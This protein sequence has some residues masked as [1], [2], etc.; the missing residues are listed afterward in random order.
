VTDA[1]VILTGGA[2]A[3]TAVAGAAVANR[4]RVPGL[5]LF[6]AL[7]MAVGS[8]GAGWLAF[9]DYDAAQR[10]GTIALAL[11]L[12]EGGLATGVETIRHVL[13][14]AIHL[15]VVGTIVTAL[16]TGIIASALLQV[17]L[18]QGMLLGAVLSSTDGAAIFALLRGS[19]LRRRLARTLEAESGL[20]DPIAVILVVGLIA[21]I[22]N[23]GYGLIDMAGLFVR[24]LS[25]GAACGGLVAWASTAAVKRVWLPTQGLYPVA[26]FGAAALAYGAAASLG[27][28]SFLAVYLVGLAFASPGIPARQT[29]AAFHA[30]AAWIGQIALFVSLGLLVAP[31]QLA[32]V[33]AE[34]TLLALAIMLVARPL[35]TLVA[36][37]RDRFSA[38]EQLVLSWAGLRGGVPV[39]FATFPVTAGVPGSTRFFDIVFFAVVLS[40]F[41]QGATFER[42]AAR[43]GLTTRTPALPR[44]LTDVGVIRG[45]G[46]EVAE[47]GLAEGD[48]VIGRHVRDLG[49]PSSAI[50][51]IIVRGEE[52]VLPRGSTRLEAGDVLH[53]LIRDEVA[54]KMPL[55]VERWRHGD[56]AADQ[57]PPGPAR[58]DPARPERLVVQPWHPG[59]GDAAHPAAVRGAPVVGRLLG[60]SDVRGALVRLDDGRLAATGPVLAVGRPHEVGRYAVER[61]RMAQ[62]PAERSWWE[63]VAAA[64]DGGSPVRPTPPPGPARSARTP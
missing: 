21:W 16:V 1:A 15:A 12:F 11:I 45:L 5:L 31:S 14:P 27:G 39:V 30:G 7:G 47:V 40:T 61:R 64:A 34:G 13:R 32:G 17:S 4:L 9:T 59:L 18:L 2:L 50:V 55:L 23:P 37:A 49:L 52:A 56:P 41:L 60:R 6:L 46:A 36:T 58:T 33:A 10:I 28:S 43:F 22:G 35:A 62:T 54:W 42:V 26:S 20:N 3:A 63:R 44:P 29:I 48:D 24:E 19:T 8:E 57:A 51:T 38:A 25:V 53:L